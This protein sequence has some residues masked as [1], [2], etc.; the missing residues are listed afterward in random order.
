MYEYA[1]NKHACPTD[2]TLQSVVYQVQLSNLSTITAPCYIT[3]INSVPLT[4]EKMLPGIH[5]LVYFSCCTEMRT[6]V[7]HYIY[8]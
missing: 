8:K 7:Y 2:I 5:T 1:V 6:D 3:L 4:V